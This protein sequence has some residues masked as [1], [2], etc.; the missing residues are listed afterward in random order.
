MSVYLVVVKTWWWCNTFFGLFIVKVTRY[1]M[2]LT[3]RTKDHIK[4]EFNASH[5]I[6]LMWRPQPRH[7]EEVPS[8]D[9]HMTWPPGRS[10]PTAKPYN[11]A[12]I[13]IKKPKLF[14]IGVLEIILLIHLIRNRELAVR[15]E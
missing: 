15:M 3:P 14:I 7:Y 10:M 8:C 2:Q 13:M 11:N 12:Y 9:C 4:G 5:V 1:I 6:T